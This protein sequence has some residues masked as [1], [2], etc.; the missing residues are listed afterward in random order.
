M[1]N[2]CH[3]SYEDR[4]NIEDG[5]NENKSINQ[6]SKEI[7]RSH[8]S[9]LREIDRNKKYS[10]PSAWNNYK[11]NHP[12]L[13]LSC[14]RLK[15]SPYVCNGCKS[16]SGCRKVRWTYYAREADNSYKEVKSE[17][18]K[19]INLTPEE[20]YKI[21]SI[22][23]PLIKKGQTIN[24]LYINHPDILDFSKPSF[25]NYV[26]NGVF[27]F[28][29]LDFPRIVKYKKRKNS[30]NRRTRKEREILI[31]RKHDDFQKFISNHPDFNI[32]EMD[33]V[34]GLKDEN[35]CFLTLLWRKSKFMLIFKLESQTSEEVSRIFNILQT[36]IPYDDYKRL[37]E[38][39]LTDNGHEFFDVLNIECMHSTGEQVTKLFF[40]DPHMS[41]QKGMIE[42]N[43]EF[44]R[45][46]LPKGSSFKNITQ[47]DCDLFMNNIN[48]LCRDSLNG[49][50]PYEA[51]LFLCDEYV[52]KSLN[53][54][55]IKPDEVILNDS[56]LKY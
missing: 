10:E 44:I 40:C 38:V 31:N 33:T 36:L 42:K 11:I 20:V 45:Y 2:Y 1:A 35:D 12:D 52:L 5:L 30:K 29:P 18:R 9:I 26:N 54:Y 19:G 56:L 27:E 13:D 51:M 37:F 47:E 8:S 23:T 53:C 22:L 32:V 14:E 4:K 21:N 7:N 34:E 43:H 25:Y 39:I 50:S 41:C 49:K 16:R 17:A 24:H 15:H 46:I 28:S 3:L 55:Y 48:S 6:I